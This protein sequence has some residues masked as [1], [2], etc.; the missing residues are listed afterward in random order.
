V[1]GHE[2]RI[3]APVFVEREQTLPGDPW[4]QLKHHDYQL[5]MF[6]WVSLQAIK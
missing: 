4:A 5:S 6:A 2:M 1:D 3:V